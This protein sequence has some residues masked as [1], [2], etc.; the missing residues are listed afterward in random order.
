QLSWLRRRSAGECPVPVI[1]TAD[2]R[3][4]TATVDARDAVCWLL[5]TLPR[6]QRA[7]LVLRLFED[8][9]DDD[10]A[11]ILQCRPGTVRAHAS[12]G[13]ATLREHPQLRRAGRA[14]TTP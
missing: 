12:K 5:A 14:E 1:E 10:I 2:S 11:E 7:V 9:D 6:R 3:D 13:L 8:L 4:D